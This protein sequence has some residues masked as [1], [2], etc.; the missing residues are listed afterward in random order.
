MGG[1]QVCPVDHFIPN[2]GDRF[3]PSGGWVTFVRLSFLLPHLWPPPSKHLRSRITISFE[4]SL[5]GENVSFF[6]FV[7]LP[8]SSSCYF[9][10]F[11]TRKKL[12][13]GGLNYPSKQLIAGGPEAVKRNRSKNKFLPRERIDRLLDPGASFLEL[14]QYRKIEIIPANSASEKKDIN[15]NDQNPS[16]DIVVYI[17]VHESNLTKEGVQNNMGYS[18]VRVANLILNYIFG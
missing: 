9:S 4:A 13:F 7:D 14:S 3:D 6:Y 8:S 2:K 10:L 15:N 1:G 18:S 5:A 16:E 17:Y 11:F 12:D